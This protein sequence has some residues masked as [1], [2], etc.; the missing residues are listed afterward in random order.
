MASPPSTDDKFG[1]HEGRPIVEALHDRL[2]VHIRRVSG[3]SDLAK[4]MRYAIRH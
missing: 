1:R 3:A 4:A 2:H